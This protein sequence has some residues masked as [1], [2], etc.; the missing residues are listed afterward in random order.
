M[1]VCTEGLALGQRFSGLVFVNFHRCVYKRNE[2]QAAGRRLGFHKGKGEKVEV[3]RG[4]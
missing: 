4:F 1:Y 2:I 3:I